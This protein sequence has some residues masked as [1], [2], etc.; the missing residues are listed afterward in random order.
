LN[1]PANVNNGEMIRM[2][3]AGEAVPGGIAGDLYV[4][5]HVKDDTQFKKEGYNLITT[6]NVKLS[7]AL[8]GSEYAVETLDGKIKVKIPAGARPNETLR[9]RNKGVPHTDVR[10][11]D[12]LIKLNIQLPKKLSRKAKKA[13]EELREEGI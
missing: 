10:R 3:G 2:N 7:D 12:L 6:L 5:L 11:G 9:V 1:I 4:K 13:V 8:L